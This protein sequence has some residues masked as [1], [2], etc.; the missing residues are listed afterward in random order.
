MSL[1]FSID[2]RQRSNLLVFKFVSLPIRHASLLNLPNSG[3]QNFLPKVTQWK[4]VV[5]IIIIIIIRNPL[6]L[7]IVLYLKIY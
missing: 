1:Y 7:A 6:K 3:A 2:I 5:V 4:E